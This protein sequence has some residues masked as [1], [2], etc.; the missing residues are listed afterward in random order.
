M[1]PMLTHITQPLSRRAFL[2]GVGVTMALPWLESV[3]VWGDDKPKNSSSE[4]PVRFAV[5][6]AGNGFHSKEW[7]A[8]GEGKDMQVGKVLEPL[9]PFREK[10]LFLRGLY[11]AEALIGGI[12]SCQTGNLLTGAHLAPG[13]E[14]KSG[15]SCDQVI[16][17]K[18]KGQTKVPS[19]VLGTEP[20]IAAIHKN[21]SMIYSS[22]ISWSSAT[23]PTPLELYPALAF[24][25]LF[26]DEVGKAD[27]SVLDAVR[28]DANSYK[29]K[30]SIADQR[31]LDEYLSSVREVEQRIED[32]GKN[33]RF[34]GWRPTLE[35]PD[36]KRPADGIPQD[37]DQHMRLMCDILVLAFRTDT[38]RVCTLKLNNDHSSLRF[39][40]LPATGGKGGID[41]MI[42]HLLSHTDGADW[43]K[44]NQF[45]TRQVGYVCEKL[46]AV[47]EGDRTLLDNSTVLYCSSMMTGNHNNDQLPVVVL[48]KGGG[49]IKTGRV[50]DYLG[51]PNRKMCS[52]YL[53]LMEK[54]GVRLKEF[55]DSK[56]RL[57]EI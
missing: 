9:H 52:L 1:N 47:K 17:E 28:D 39:P 37:I 38:T 42:H 2:R 54:A 50:L 51:K 14:I 32:A 53:S 15:V 56:E 45:F 3:P 24:D 34:Q 5:L 46:D 13:G 30:V 20:P 55:G 4:P 44:V 57:A 43:L 33:G 12:H 26:R 29:N 18:T 35:K 25:R 31:R 11:N 27:R 6:F 49:R 41:Y 23:T 7:W 19:L 22:H 40:N 8:K 48:G 10:M 36:M 21:Y 16:A